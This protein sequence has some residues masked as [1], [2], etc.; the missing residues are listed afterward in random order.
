M[1]QRQVRRNGPPSSSPRQSIPSGGLNDMSTA[2]VRNGNLS[3][4]FDLSQGI[5]IDSIR[6]LAIGREYLNS[7]SMLFEYAVNNAIR[8]SNSSLSVLATIAAS[9]GSGLSVVAFDGQ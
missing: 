4:G 5:A 6:D 3:I 9:D 8:E 7:P 1:G 2:D